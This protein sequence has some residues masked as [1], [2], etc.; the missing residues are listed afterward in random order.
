M[1]ITLTHYDEL[2]GVPTHINKIGGKLPSNMLDLVT[3]TDIKLVALVKNIAA[4]LK[5]MD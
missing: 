2:T 5:A 4:T 1:N 3:A